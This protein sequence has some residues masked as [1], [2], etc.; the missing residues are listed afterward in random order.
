MRKSLFRDRNVFLHAPLNILNL[1][2]CLSCG[3]AFL[4]LIPGWEQVG[5]RKTD[6]QIEK[7]HLLIHVGIN[8]II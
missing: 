5:W 7:K 3:D 8:K 6:A 4:L 2:V 1:Y